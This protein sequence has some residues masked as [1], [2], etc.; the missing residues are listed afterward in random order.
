MRTFRILTLLALLGCLVYSCSSS[1]NQNKKRRITGVTPVIQNPNRSVINASGDGLTPGIG[2]LRTAGSEENAASIANNAIAKANQAVKKNLQNLEV[3]TEEQ[4]ADKMVN[5]LQ[6]EVQLCKNTQEKTN[7]TQVKAY[8]K[9]ILNDHAQ[10]QNDLKK[11]SALKNVLSVAPKSTNTI[12][13]T[14][15]DFVQMVIESNQ[16]LIAIYTVGSKSKDITIRT[17]ALKYLP[18]LKTHLEAAQELTKIIKP[19]QKI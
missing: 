19:A 10:I 11:L 16:N 8:A 7:N 5:E 14:D 17:L 3:L 6:T 18:V 2:Q 9:T 1:R 15:L 4:L 12:A 13:K